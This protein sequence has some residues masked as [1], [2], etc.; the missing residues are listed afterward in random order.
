MT[1][2]YKLTNVST[3]GDIEYGWYQGRR[4]GVLHQRVTVADNASQHNLGVKVPAQSRMIWAAVTA[5]SL[6]AVDGDSTSTA[7]GYVLMNFGTATGV[8]T[9]TA[10]NYTASAVVDM[11]SNLAS[12]SVTRV[13]VGSSTTTVF[14]N[15][16]STEQL[17]SLV[18][19]QT[20][21][22]VIHIDTNGLLFNGTADVDV[23]IYFEDYADR[24]TKQH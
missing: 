12:N 7:D 17:L 3:A 11:G 24:Y 4:A 8:A 9:T 14:I 5:H 21:S 22:N 2:G 18:P 19:I 6:V 10:S 13:N 23:T 16:A 1:I 20:T 15:T